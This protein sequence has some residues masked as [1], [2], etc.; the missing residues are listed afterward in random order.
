VNYNRYTVDGGLAGQAW[1]SSIRYGYWTN[2]LQLADTTGVVRAFSIITAVPMNVSGG[3]LT[4]RLNAY[5]STW[6][7]AAD[8]VA[9]GRA[10]TN[11]TVWIC[12]DTSGVIEH[13]FP[14]NEVAGLISSAGSGASNEYV[15]WNFAGV[16]AGYYRIWIRW[17][18]AWNNTTNA[19]YSVFSG[20][21]SN[22]LGAQSVSQKV[23]PLQHVQDRGVW[24]QQMTNGAAPDGAYWIED[25]VFGVRLQAVD[26]SSGNDYTRA[27]AVRVEWVAPIEPNG[28]VILIR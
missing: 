22:I 19:V 24:W 27:D 14:N 11:R 1:L 26:N 3:T 8:A 21:A 25:D 6:N 12:D 10:T 23:E 16:P 13:N 2:E 9:V 7:M 5:T 28:T 4:V 15:R 17:R 18:D 20:D